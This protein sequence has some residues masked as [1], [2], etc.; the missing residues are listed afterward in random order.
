MNKTIFTFTALFLAAQL[1]QA[2]IVR[3]NVV[4]NCKVTYGDDAS[5]PN[6]PLINPYG[7]GELVQLKTHSGLEVELLVYTE[8]NEDDAFLPNVADKAID[9][10]V[11]LTE[12][13]TRTGTSSMARGIKQN[14]YSANGVTVSNT[15]LNAKNVKETLTVQC[16]LTT[17]HTE[18]AKS[19]GSIPVDGN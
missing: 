2:G 8:L 5:G 11:E 18:P 7:G 17:V 9:L 12:K 6:Y 13:V 19:S 15:Y 14:R 1:T 16:S 3:P 10:S 4:V